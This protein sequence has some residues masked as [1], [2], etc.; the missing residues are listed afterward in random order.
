[1]SKSEVIFFL[2]PGFSFLIGGFTIYL[3]FQARSLG[4]MSPS[5]LLSYVSEHSFC[6]QNV[7]P[8]IPTT[9]SLVQQLF[10]GL[11]VSS[12]HTNLPQSSLNG[13]ASFPSQI[14][15]LITVP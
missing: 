11:F 10:T 2:K 3:V 6:S 8:A 14:S 7:S 1:M 12:P 9:A 15:H 5:T 13:A 4:D